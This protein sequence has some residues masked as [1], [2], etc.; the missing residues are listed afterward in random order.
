MR[1]CTYTC[2]RDPEDPRRRRKKERTR[3]RMTKERKK[4][5]MRKRMTKERKE[6]EEGRKERKVFPTRCYDMIYDFPQKRSCET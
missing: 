4:E 5:R 6:G 2:T 3:K 1:C